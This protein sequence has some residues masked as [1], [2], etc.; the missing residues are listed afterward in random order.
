MHDP[1]VTVRIYIIYLIFHSLACFSLIQIAHMKYWKQFIV[2]ILLC[3]V[4][5]PH[6]ML[7]YFENTFIVHHVTHPY[8]QFNFIASL[9][10]GNWTI[11]EQKMV[12]TVLLF[13]LHTPIVTFI[14]Y[15]WSVIMMKTSWPFN[16]IATL[17]WGNILHQKTGNGFIGCLYFPNSL[18]I[19]L[20][21]KKTCAVLHSNKNNFIFILGRGGYLG[22]SLNYLG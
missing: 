19:F 15:S 21:V 5:P 11:A 2:H 6:R 22:G 3:V 20:P 7:W 9:R 17:G 10:C 18:Y 14:F 13:H 1:L 16:F 8:R 12:Q 4:N